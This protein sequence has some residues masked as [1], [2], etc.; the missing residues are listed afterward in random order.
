MS[1][2]K[3]PRCSASRSVAV[4]IEVPAERGRVV[5]QALAVPLGAR[6][7]RFDDPP[8]R[9][10]QRFGRLEI[11]GEAFEPHQ[12]S[13]ARL[14][15][16]G[17][18]RLVEEV[19]GASVEAVEA[20]L[21]LLRAADQHHRRQ[22]RIGAA[23]QLGA[24]VEPR[25]ARHHDV[26]QHEIRAL[27]PDDLERVAAVGRGQHRVVGAF[28]QQ[29][30]AAQVRL[31]VVDDQHL[32]RISTIGGKCRA[33]SRGPDGILRN[34]TRPS[35]GNAANLQRARPDRQSCNSDATLTARGRCA[36][37]MPSASG[38]LA[39]LRLD[40]AHVAR[41]HAQQLFLRRRQ[42]L[43]P[44]V[45]VAIADPLRLEALRSV[46]RRRAQ[47]RD[48]RALQRAVER[49]GRCRDRAA[50]PRCAASASHTASRRRPD[51]PTRPRRR[52][53]RSDRSCADR[54]T[55]LPSRVDDAE[56]RRRAQHLQMLGRRRRLRRCSR[57]RR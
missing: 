26:E 27:A 15:F 2:R 42:R 49:I 14:Q 33:A 19:V 32:F 29:A 24:D 3:A 17:V 51:R 16:L 20:R 35:I 41:A 44:I 11:V 25:D 1:W 57:R 13:D 53:S 34:A 46:D 47:Q 18:D 21:A 5:G 54:S 23:F 28:E 10:E 31:V 39:Q 7:A 36:A 37:G 8:E 30:E 22:A 50:R 45:G 52:S 40:H 55:V 6:I 9:Q 43:E 4:E 12:R 56:R 38:D 48:D